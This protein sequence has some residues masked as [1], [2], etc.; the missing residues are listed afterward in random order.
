MIEFVTPRDGAFGASDLAD[1]VGFDGEQA[2]EFGDEPPRSKW[3]VAMAGVVVTGL[4]GVGIIAA[5]PWGSTPDAAP[6]TTV[7]SAPQSTTAPEP[8]AMTTVTTER[9]GDGDDTEFDESTRAAS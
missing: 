3:L 1:F 2:A 7:A 4:I 5:A 6:T 8:T 9:S